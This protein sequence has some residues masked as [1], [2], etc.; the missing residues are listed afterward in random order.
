MQLSP[1]LYYFYCRVRT[2]VIFTKAAN[3]QSRLRNKIE[4]VIMEDP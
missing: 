1:G 2:Q 4:T 3:S